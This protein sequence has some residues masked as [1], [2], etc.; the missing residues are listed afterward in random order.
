MQPL[1][2][3]HMHECEAKRSNVQGCRG[4]VRNSQRRHRVSIRALHL[5]GFVERGDVGLRKGGQIEEV[6]TQVRAE[7]L[8][9][10]MQRACYGSA[11]NSAE[12]HKHRRAIHAGYDERWLK[13]VQPADGGR[14]AERSVAQSTHERAVEAVEHFRLRI[15]PELPTQPL[16]LRRA[17]GRH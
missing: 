5:C 12:S 6:L 11:S 10:V 16:A 9:A 3:R 8:S 1:A 7:G 14:P 4:G 17:I 2:T 15:V 13:L